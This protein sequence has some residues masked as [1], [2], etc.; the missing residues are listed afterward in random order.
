[1]TTSICNQTILGKA[2]YTL[3]KYR[4]WDCIGGQS[5]IST[6]ISCLEKHTISA[7]FCWLFH[8]GLKG[9]AYGTCPYPIN[10]SL[11]SLF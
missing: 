8:D 10:D 5:G 1:M 9:C 11:F 2:Y 3:I 7:L 6:E 4:W